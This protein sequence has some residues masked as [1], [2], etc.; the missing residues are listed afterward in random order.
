MWIYLEERHIPYRVKTVPLN[1]YGDKPAWYSRLVDGGNVPAIELHGTLF[2][3]SLEIIKVLN[4]EFG[5][6]RFIIDDEL[7]QLDKRVQ[8]DWFSL[9]FYPVEGKTLE[10]TREAFLETMRAVNDRLGA[11]QGPWFGGRLEPS[12]IDIILIPTME[13]IEASILYWR[14][15]KLRGVYPN[16]DAWLKAWE[17]HPS[18]MATKSDFFTLC[19]AMPSQNGPGYFSP[20]A[21]D[22]ASQIYGLDGAWSLGNDCTIEQV[23]VDDESARFEALYR[24]IEN[25]ASLV[26]FCAR[27]AGEPGTPSFHAELA[28]PY[29]EPNEEF[30]P[31]I[32]TCLRHV[33][34]AL[35]NGA[36]SVEKLAYHDLQGVCVNEELLEGWEAYEEDGRTYYWNHETGDVAWTPPT[37]DLSGCLAYLRDRVGVPRDMSYPAARQLRMHLNWAIEILRKGV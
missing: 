12:V 8:Q 4:Q 1:A 28:D 14:N 30:V 37:G 32:D 19:S 6:S 10:N 5:T 29:A 3:E 20:D 9:V 33:A 16:I 18:Y 24:M 26:K 25:H 15:V 36:N 11:T 34:N 17:E 35:L 22:V 13:R 31:A 23:N 27:A 7:M 2:T 21:K